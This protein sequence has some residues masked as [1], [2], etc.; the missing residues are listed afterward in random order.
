MPGAVEAYGIHAQRRLQIGRDLAEH[1]VNLDH[2]DRRAGPVQ[3][4]R[5]PEL[6]DHADVDAGLEAAAEV[7]RQFVRLP[8]GAG[9]ED[10][11]ARGHTAGSIHQL[12]LNLFEGLAFCFRQLGFEEQEAE[13]ADGGVNPEGHRRAKVL[14][15][16][17]G[18]SR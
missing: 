17:R 11:F 6:I 9:G 8:V 12:L 18:R 3:P 14:P 16:Q 15:E 13:E 5:L 4:E 2:L 10:A 7:H 1:L